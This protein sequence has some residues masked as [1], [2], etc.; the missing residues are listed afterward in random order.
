[1]RILQRQRDA[2]AY[3]QDRRAP[4]HVVKALGDLI[5]MA[6]RAYQTRS[7]GV[8]GTEAPGDHPLVMNPPAPPD[9]RNYN[10]S[11][12][13]PFTAGRQSIV[14]LPQNY[15]RTLLIIQNLDIAASLY[16]NLG[17]GASPQNGVLLGAGQGIILDD[18]CPSDSLNVYFDNGTPCM[19]IALEMRFTPS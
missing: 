10:T 13:A 9:Y 3:L 15:M 12:I 7:D 16:F 18:V 19:G 1:M 6:E 4:V 2:L 5:D 11:F 8:F 17:S 14:V